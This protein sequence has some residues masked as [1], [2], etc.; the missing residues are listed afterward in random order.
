MAIVERMPPVPGDLTAAE[1]VRRVA[2]SLRMDLQEQLS[3]VE[4]G[5]L[6]HYLGADGLRFQI[7]RLDAFIE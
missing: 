7:A 5:R 6:H 1:H 3:R 4:S 2:R